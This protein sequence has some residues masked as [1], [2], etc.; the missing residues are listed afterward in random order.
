MTSWL[1]PLP[2]P[3]WTGEEAR[4]AAD[5]I[6]RDERYRTPPPSL[7]ERALDWFG[8]R[9]SDLFGDLF[10]GG[11]LDIVGWLLIAAAIAL[12]IWF[13]TRLQ[14]SVALD[15]RVADA[16]VMVELTRSPREWRDEAA[17]LEAQGRFK[18]ALRCLYRALVADLVAR[19]LIPEIP[20]RTAG[21]YV[22]DIAAGAPDVAVAFAA[23]TELFELAWYADAPTGAHEC[24]RFRALD[25][26][27]LGGVRS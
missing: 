7:I 9:L 8:D 2:P 13:V 16:E 17:A 22:R 1:G 21:E 15:R 19:E 18:E 26:Q 25:A 24:A 6:L 10:E 23:A 20:G 14:G 27:V 12:V 3:E 5:E 4:D 11:A